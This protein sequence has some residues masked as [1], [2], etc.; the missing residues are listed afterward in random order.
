[1]SDINNRFFNSINQP[2]MVSYNMGKGVPGSYD[3]LVLKP[4]GGSDWRKPPSNV[5]LMEGKFFVPQGTP[6][7][8]KNEMQ[9]MSLP[10]DSMFVFDRNVSSPSCCPSTFST[11]TGCVCT[12]KQQRDFIGQRRG[13]NKNHFDD[14]F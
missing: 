13:N 7:P 5:P 6:L 11:S 4:K 8:L 12:T 9:F 14:S 10:K 1:M 3:G 2:A